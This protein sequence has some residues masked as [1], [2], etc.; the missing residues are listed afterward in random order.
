MMN[1]GET[2]KGTI[3]VVGAG[4]IGL[5][6]GL[7]LQQQG[8][9]VTLFDPHGAGNGCSKGNAGHIATEQIFP[10]ATPG[11]LPQLPKMLW[12]SDGP[13]SVR[14]QDLP[15]TL[16]WMLRFLFQARPT[17]TA[18]ATQALIGL[19]QK[20]VASWHTLLDSI[21][22]RELLK[23]DGSLLTFESERLFQRYQPT[24]KA[25][26]AAGVACEI[27]SAEHIRER[28]PV[29]SHH[30]HAGVFFPQTGHSIEPYHL[31]K[32][33]ER[34]LL[35]LGG[36]VEACEVMKIRPSGTLLTERGQVTCDKVIIA[37]GAYSAPL[38]RDLTGVR[39]PLQAERGYH[40]MVSSPAPA[41]PFPVSSADRKFIMTPMTGGLRLAG[42]VEYAD[43]NAPANMRRA[44][45]LLSM[46]DTLLE[47]GL[48]P[49]QKGDTWMGNRPST[50]DSLPVID[51][52]F[53]GRI[54]LAFGHQHLGLTQAAITADL[55]AAMVNDDTPALDVAPFT[56]QRFA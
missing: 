37:A 43:I 34:A 8:Y 21:G 39:V 32:T 42:T 11:L 47:Q 53:D 9:Q 4:V 38:V 49:E 16:G 12:A 44:D 14:W 40:L 25:L 5:A 51:Q 41:L 7:K 3:G 28:V 29:L 22:R 1:Q 24:L 48:S 36:S 23:M 13:V 33:L 54:L 18:R 17:A 26:R 30:V 15:K 27:W 35:Q 6:I 52:C 56:L 50:C 2:K 19:N 55:I 20:A 10:L 45:M 46:A 31:C